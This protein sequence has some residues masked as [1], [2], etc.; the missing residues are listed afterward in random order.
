MTLA[1]GAKAPSFTLISDENQA[2]SLQDFTG[3]KV[4]VYF[5]PKDDT[6]GC[7]QE[8]CDFR[9]TL[10]KFKKQNTIILGI[11]KDDVEKHIKFK[12]KYG[13]SFPLLADIDGKVCNAYG[14]I[15]EKI[16]YGRKYIGIERSTFLINEQG[17]I[18]QVWRKVKV[19]GHI[20][21]VLGSI[22]ASMSK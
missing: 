6:P 15:V 3:K 19:A 20:E 9:D 12:E 8:A 18:E 1:I 4:V 21:E 5:Y 7:T 22:S 2:V 16:N 17:K 10:N 13:L 14:V 11:S